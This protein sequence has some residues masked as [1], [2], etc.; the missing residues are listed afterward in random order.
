MVCKAKKW[1]LREERS[2]ESFVAAEDTNA[3]CEREDTLTFFG[4]HIQPCGPSTQ[5]CAAIDNH[6]PRNSFVQPRLPWF[7]STSN[8]KQAAAVASGITDHDCATS[9][10]FLQISEQLSQSLGAASSK[11]AVNDHEA[12]YTICSTIDAFQLSA[13]GLCGL[14]QGTSPL[15]STQ[16]LGFVKYDRSKAA[17]LNGLKETKKSSSAGSLAPRTGSALVSA[18]ISNC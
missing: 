10:M 3:K 13:T 6:M 1:C 9:G 5:P 4:D 8:E 14:P 12:F 16:S 7:M 18:L 17:M 11:T 2:V 15:P